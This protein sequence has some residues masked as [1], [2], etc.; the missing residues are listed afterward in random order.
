MTGKAVC[1]LCR[2]GDPAIT[3]RCFVCETTFHIHKCQLDMVSEGSIFMGD[4]PS[5]GVINCWKKHKGKIKYS[6]TVIYD[7]QPIFDLRGK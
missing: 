3:V 1:K 6:G 4:C 2:Q 7:E 5:C